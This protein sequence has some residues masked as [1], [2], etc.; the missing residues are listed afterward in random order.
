METTKKETEQ[1][2]GEYYLVETIGHFCWYMELRS[3]TYQVFKENATSK[4]MALK[5]GKGIFDKYLK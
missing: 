1:Q 3:E 2:I 4:Q 5:Y